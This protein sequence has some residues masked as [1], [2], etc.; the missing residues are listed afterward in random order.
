[1]ACMAQRLQLACKETHRISLVSLEVVHIR[2]LGVDV[3]TQ[4]LCTPWIPGKLSH[5]DA[6]PPGCVVQ[7]LPL[8]VVVSHLRPA[9]IGA[10]A[11]FD[12]GMAAR[13]RAGSERSV[14]H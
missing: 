5:P 7:A 3:R 4:T 13:I 1:M 9:M 6:A 10:P 8:R 2:S 12:Q 14:W 11:R